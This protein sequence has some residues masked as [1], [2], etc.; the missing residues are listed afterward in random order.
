M[1]ADRFGDAVIDV[2]AEELVARVDEGEVAGGGRKSQVR[3]HTGHDVAEHLARR[4]SVPQLGEN[5]ES[6]W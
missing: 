5:T 2:D 3:E 4:N 6:G 1:R